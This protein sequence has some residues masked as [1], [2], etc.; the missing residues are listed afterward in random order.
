MA[1]KLAAINNQLVLIGNEFLAIPGYTATTTQPSGTEIA[2][3]IGTLSVMELKRCADAISE[4]N[5]ITSETNVCYVEINSDHDYYT[6]D[7]TSTTD[8]ISWTM[9]G[10]SY[11]FRIIG[12]NHYDKAEGS[13]KAGIL[14]QMVDCFNTS[15]NMC[16]TK[17]YDNGWD[18]S[19]LRNTMNATIYR[20]LPRDVKDSISPVRILTAKNVTT[21]TIITTNDKIFVPAEVEIFGTASRAIGGMN[22]GS[23]YAWYRV[24]NTAANRIKKVN[25]TNKA[26]WCRSPHKWQTSQATFCYVG[27][28]GQIGTGFVQFD[29]SVSACFCF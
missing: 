1:T 18:N 2:A 6:L 25:G 3:G 20:Y 8:S 10:T 19:D 12:F 24:N 28:S 26:W 4:C 15:Y 7:A 14:F 11:A 16:S 29:N 13:G 17:S 5:S 21:S 27:N 22:E 23:L 9:N